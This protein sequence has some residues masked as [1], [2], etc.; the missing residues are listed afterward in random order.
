MKIMKPYIL[1]AILT[2]I[3][4][5]NSNKTENN[6]G[7]TAN[8][9]SQTAIDKD[10][11]D[12]TEN[13][14]L[15]ITDTIKKSTS[16]SFS[17][18]QSKDLFLLTIE[19]G[20]VKNSKSALQIITADNKI[21]Y[22]QT[23]DTYYFIKWIY[24]P[25]T[26]PTTGGQEAYEKYMENYWKS[27]TPKQ[28]ETHFKKSVDSFFDAVYPMKKKKFENLKAWEEDITDKDFLNEVLA[29]STIQLFDITCFDCD[30]GA[31][32]IGYSRKQHKVVTLVE[33]D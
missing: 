29:D 23:F 9:S 7:D 27:I 12:R 20:M 3:L 8:D 21:I 25:D 15:S 11:Y 14:K 10:N 18:Q 1:L 16:Y 32:V 30:E 26:I 6:Q 33:H 2:T 5:C 24:E 31:A 22:T 4:S 19:P 28:Y 17:N 13:L